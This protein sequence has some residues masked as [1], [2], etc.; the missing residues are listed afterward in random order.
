M[1]D[2]GKKKPKN[3]V[4]KKETA[5]LAQRIEILDWH[6]KN[7]QNQSNTAKH[8]D[9]VYPNLKIKQPLVS[10]WIRNEAAWRERFGAAGIQ[11]QKSKRYGHAKFPKVD[12]A[13]KLWVTKSM[14]QDLIITGEVI[15]QKW[16]AFADL[17]KIPETDRLT[18]SDGWL[19][20]FKESMGLVNIKRHGEAASAN[21]H[22]VEEERKRIQVILK[23]YKPEDMWNVDETGLFYA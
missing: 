4:G 21:P 8:F 12:A 18:L 13:L 22:S 15:R 5:T 23:D 6:H 7:G 11:G 3:E 17:A 1:G 10:D 2:K 14:E 9:K 19:A 20:N 16:H